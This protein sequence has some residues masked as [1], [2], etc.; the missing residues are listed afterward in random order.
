M[1]ST[2]YTV[3]YSVFKIDDFLSALKRFGVTFLVDVRSVP[4]SQY[5]KNYN[6][7]ALSESLSKC[8]IKY[9]NFK[10]EFG[11]RQEDKRYY[12]NGYL[13]YD[14]FAVSP[15]F[16]NGIARVKKIMANGD[17][18]CL[19]CAEKD[20]INC[21]RAILC[22]RYLQNAGFEIEHIIPQKEGVILEKQSDLEKR[23]SDL[24]F[25]SGQCEMFGDEK[26]RLSESYNRQN[27]KIGY[28]GGLF[29]DSQLSVELYF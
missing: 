24:Y 13:D 12:P 4:R 7:K 14:K 25:K 1:Q 19:M 10:A 8:K 20:P 9:A 11:A 22:G 16:Q 21:H 28:E 17:V 15:Q 6:E 29:R 3:G 27:A 2:I 23:L 18:I 26:S 5:F